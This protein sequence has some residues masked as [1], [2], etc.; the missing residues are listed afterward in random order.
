MAVQSSTSAAS[1]AIPSHHLAIIW[2]GNQHAMPSFFMPCVASLPHVTLE[3]NGAAASCRIYTQLSNRIQIY[4]AVWITCVCQHSRSKSEGCAR[5]EQKVSMPSSA[6]TLQ[7]SNAQ[8]P[9]THAYTHFTYIY[10]H[11]QS[12]LTKQISLSSIFS[13]SPRS[14]LPSSV[15]HCKC[16]HWCIT[17]CSLFSSSVAYSQLFSL[18]DTI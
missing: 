15:T 16:L 5:E 14:S 3:G 6:C 13:N 11:T 2:K 7:N 4:P 17:N 9:H 18:P 12:G 10:T 8:F 1:T